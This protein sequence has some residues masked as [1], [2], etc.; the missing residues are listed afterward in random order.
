VAQGNKVGRFIRTIQDEC[1]SRI[2]RKV[3]NLEN[4]ACIPPKSLYFMG[5]FRIST[6]NNIK[7]FLQIPVKALFEKPENESI[8]SI[9]GKSDVQKQ[10]LTQY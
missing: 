6:T 5:F 9:F 3:R 4:S 7:K 8:F 1:L 2:S 10:K